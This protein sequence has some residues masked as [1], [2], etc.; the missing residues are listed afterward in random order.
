M[1]GFDSVCCHLAVINL[2]N[3][4]VYAV[5][6][7]ET[8]LIHAFQNIIYNAIEAIPAEGQIKFTAKFNKKNRSIDFIIADTGIGISPEVTQNIF[9]PFYT[10]KAKGFGIG[11]TAAKEVVEAHGGNIAVT[12]KIG[13][14]TTFTITLPVI[15]FEAWCD[16]K[17]RG[18]ITWKRF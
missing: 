1:K 10:T 17:D 5:L 2:G 8:R 3:G 15:Q 18:D 14:G 4:Y 7:D 12:S 16:I 11:L 13:K 6:K 9:Q